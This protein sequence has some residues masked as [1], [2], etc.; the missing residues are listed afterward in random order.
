MDLESALVP[1][2]R[3]LRALLEGVRSAIDLGQSL[4]EAI[5]GVAASEKSQW[6]LWDSTQPR[7]VT[8]VYDQLEWQ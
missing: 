3:Y 5:D 8:R 7:N 1:E 2:R 4:P 6:L